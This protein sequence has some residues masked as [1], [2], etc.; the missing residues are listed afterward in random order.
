MKQFFRHGKSR[1]LLRIS[2][3]AA[4]AA[5]AGLILSGQERSTLRLYNT[6]A[7]T[8]EREY[9]ETS[10]TEEIKM[11]VYMDD[12]AGFSVLVPSDWTPVKND[13]CQSYIQ[14]ET[15]AS[16]CFRTGEYDP[17]VN[18]ASA[19]SLSRTLAQEGY[20]FAGFTR[21]SGSSYELLYQDKK[22]KIYDYIE[23]VYWD[24]DTVITISC[25]FEDEDY[26]AF[27]PYFEKIIRSFSWER[28]SP[29]PEGFHLF[30][31]EEY[32]F[33]VGIPDDWS[34]AL[35]GN[36]LAAQEDA[37]G[38]A[39]IVQAQKN[40]APLESLTAAGLSSTLEAGRENLIFGS[41]QADADHAY[42]RSTYSRNRKR[43]VNRVYLFSGKEY[44]YSL[45]FDYEEGSL[46]EDLPETCA[47]LFRSFSPEDTD[48]SEAEEEVASS[49]AQNEDT[50]E[51]IFRQIPEDGIPA[52]LDTVRSMPDMTCDSYADY[53]GS[54]HIFVTPEQK[55]KWLEMADQTISSV[56]GS[57]SEQDHFSMSVDDKREEINV[58]LSSAANTERYRSALYDL[59]ASCM[60]YQIFSG[61]ETW[62]V[63]VVT[64]DSETGNI[65]KEG[66][67]PDG[68]VEIRT[69][70][71]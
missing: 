60:Y 54:I 43:W 35:S 28:K 26:S 51:F 50:L 61:L 9:K 23:E 68:D 33:E 67:Y 65:L 46:D 22:D 70:D 36:T 55:G 49:S 47:D 25:I 58:L 62:H 64:A 20:T 39:L 14:K 27:F 11:Q 57:L 16:V 19:A 13:G 2:A 71:F 48:A 21:L 59:L 29:V 32:G 17:A 45:V 69:E 1:F 3:L 37:T 31:L 34:T 4:A 38:A 53:A 18:S 30:Y 41:F 52:F 12:G 15:G 5:F 66:T 7:P 8:A 24:R 40:T 44:L 63:H 10:E 42:A 56:T 6:P